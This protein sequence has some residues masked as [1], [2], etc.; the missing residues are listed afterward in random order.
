ME[1]EIQTNLVSSSNPPTYIHLY[2]SL[3]LTLYSGSI[4]QEL[5]LKLK[6]T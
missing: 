1:M 2:K 5:L 3:Q 4:K 6:H